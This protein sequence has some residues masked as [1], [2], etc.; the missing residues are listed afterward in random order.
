MRLLLNEQDE[1]IGFATSGNFLGG[2]EVELDIPSD[3]RPRKYKL[4]DGEVILNPDYTEPLLPVDE[5]AEAFNELQET[6]AELMLN[7]A[8][9]EADNG[10]LHEALDENQQV[11]ADLMMSLAEKGVI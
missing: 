5:D 8:E 6:N 3:Y 2:I 11:S 10:T 1:I 9:L 7:L 4:L